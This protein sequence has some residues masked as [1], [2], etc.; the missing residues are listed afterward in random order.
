MILFAGQIDQ[1]FSTHWDF[2]RFTPFLTSFLRKS[3]T[4]DDHLIISSIFIV[5]H[6]PLRQTF[7]RFDPFGTGFVVKN[8]LVQG[9]I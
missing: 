3:I 8:G 1:I 2:L 7:G 4:K 6:T 9:R 5:N